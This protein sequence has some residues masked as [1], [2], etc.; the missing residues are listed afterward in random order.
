M[1]LKMS[2][3]ILAAGY[4]SRMESLKALLPLGN[5]TVIERV[6]KLF[7]ESGIDDVRV[8]SGHQRKMLH[9]VLQKLAV[10]EVYNPDY[11][12][13][14]F[15]SVQAGVSSLGAELEAFFI[16]PVDIP[17]V[18]IA[19]IK[20]LVINYE[21]TGAKIVYPCCNGK[22]GHPPLLSKTLRTEILQWEGSYGLKGL[23]RQ[24]DDMSLNIPVSDAGILLD[25][26][27]TE[28]YQKLLEIWAEQKAVTP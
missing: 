5:S 13:G 21:Q 24:H 1:P 4:S 18:K 27:T 2:A 23:L 15:S 14:M 3:I 20:E 11:S 22:R 16:M 19:T 6:V 17:L 7:I 9:P 10:Q 28:Q 12:Q 8:V 25:M 26:D